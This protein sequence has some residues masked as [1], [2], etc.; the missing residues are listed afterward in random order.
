MAQTRNIPETFAEFAKEN[1]WNE[2]ERS[3]KIAEKYY[4]KLAFLLNQF[5]V[6]DLGDRYS[7][8][9]ESVIEFDLTPLMSFYTQKHC[10]S[11]NTAEQLTALFDDEIFPL[12][13]EYGFLYDLV[14]ETFL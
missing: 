6:T 14:L 1:D 7:D 5:T 11:Q 9:K 10:V 13:A 12:G 3:D 4:N 8:I 2:V